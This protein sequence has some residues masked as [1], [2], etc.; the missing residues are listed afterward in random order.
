MA[1]YIRQAEALCRLGAT[2]Q[3][4]A[5]FFDVSDRTLNRW[6]ITRPEFA[7]ALKRGKEPADDRVQDSL[8]H[9]AMGLEYEEAHPVKLKKIIYGADGK[10]IQEEERVEIVMVKKII[11]AD[12]TA[13]IF[14][15][16]NRRAEEWRDVQRHEHGRPGDFARMTDEE[17]LAKAEQLD[18]RIAELAEAE[19]ERLGKGRLN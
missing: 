7:E 2:D 1:E 15:L 4:L 9:K 10:K 12:T 3:E 11:P 17:L 13:A 18:Q 14:W 16:K 8:Y 5:D 6:K 19:A